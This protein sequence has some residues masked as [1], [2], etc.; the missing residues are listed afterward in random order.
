MS[1]KQ[2]RRS[3]SVSGELYD[4]LRTHCEANSTTCSGVVED[5]LRSFLGMEERAPNLKKPPIARV[6]RP[7]AA[8]VTAIRDRVSQVLP[9]VFAPTPKALEVAVTTSVLEKNGD[10]EKKPEPAKP[11]EPGEKKTGT[12]L[13]DLA[14]KIFT[15]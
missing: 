7:E 11:V 3:I 2:T 8:R 1:K 4:R 12:K 10:W 9:T 6:E 15:F 13:E 14:S 5:L